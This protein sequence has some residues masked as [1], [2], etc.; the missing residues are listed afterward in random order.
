MYA[1]FINISVRNWYFTTE[2]GIAMPFLIESVYC[3][4][5]IWTLHMAHNKLKS[6][7]KEDNIW[8][9]FMQDYVARIVC[10]EQHYT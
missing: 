3:M 8:A 1:L 2:G 9:R 5:W 4:T 7:I 6:P 10:L